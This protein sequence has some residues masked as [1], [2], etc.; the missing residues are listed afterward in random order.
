MP[1][2]TDDGAL[3]HLNGQEFDFNPQ[4]DHLFSIIH[5]P[6]LSRFMANS[7]TD[8]EAHCGECA[9]LPVHQNSNHSALNHSLVY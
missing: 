6:C 5:L 2:T 1:V 9:D 4:F 3:F 7:V 8:T